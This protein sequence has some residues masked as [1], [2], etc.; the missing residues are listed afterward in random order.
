MP[1]VSETCSSFATGDPHGRNRKI[2]TELTSADYETFFAV[3]TR[4]AFGGR[5]VQVRSAL[6]LIVTMVLS[7]SLFCNHTVVLPSLPSL[8]VSV[9][10]YSVREHCPFLESLFPADHGSGTRRTIARSAYLF[11]DARGIGGSRQF[12]LLPHQMVSSTGHSRNTQHLY[13]FIDKTTA[14]IIPRRSFATPEDYAEFVHTLREYVQRES[15]APFVEMPSYA[16]GR[17]LMAFS[18]LILIVVLFP[19]LS[20]QKLLATQPCALRKRAAT[21]ERRRHGKKGKPC[22]M[23]RV[24]SWRNRWRHFCPNEPGI[25]DVYFVGFGSS[26]EQDVFMKE[27][28]Y[29]QQLFDRRFDT[30]GRSTVL[31]NN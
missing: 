10:F 1:T 16:G 24:H 17:S 20:Y 30:R 25:V 4:K 15:A 2:E 22:S 13:V 23:L 14:H 6:I 8:P 27:V 31:I 28:L 12:V 7:V 21:G 18:A 19:R 11:P 9:L 3:A 26:D 5:A 29:A